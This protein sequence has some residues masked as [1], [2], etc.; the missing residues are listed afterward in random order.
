MVA[1]YAELIEKWPEGN[2]DASPWSSRLNH[3]ADH[4]LMACKWEKAE[5]VY[6]FA[7]DLAE[8][9]GLVLYDPQSDEVHAP[10]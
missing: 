8:R 5:E 3:S 7:Q 4:V 1:F 6:M 10:E 9:H 2:D